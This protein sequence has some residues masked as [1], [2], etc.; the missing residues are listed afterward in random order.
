MKDEV[1]KKLPEWC[2]VAIASTNKVGIVKKGIQGYFPA[3]TNLDDL[4]KAKYTYED[5]RD[6]VEELNEKMGVSVEEAKAMEFGSMFG[7]EAP[8]VEKIL[9]TKKDTAEA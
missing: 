3:E 8:G 1:S 6:V 4:F 9:N 5:V 2:Y 7:W